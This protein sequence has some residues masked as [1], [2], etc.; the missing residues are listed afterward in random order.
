VNGDEEKHL[1]NAHTYR[2][3]CS[4]FRSTPSINHEDFFN[5]HPCSR[6]LSVR[7]ESVP[8]VRDGLCK[9]FTKSSRI[10]DAWRPTM[11]AADLI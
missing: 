2:R 7:P 4:L 1:Q 8:T 5:T 11:H 6:Q 10:P 9:N 3:C